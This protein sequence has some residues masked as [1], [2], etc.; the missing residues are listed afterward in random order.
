MGLIAVGEHDCQRFS[1]RIA[2]IKVTFY[3]LRTSYFGLVSGV[4]F[5]LRFV[6]NIRYKLSMDTHSKPIAH[7]IEWLMQH[8]R[9]YCLHF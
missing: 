5:T 3:T 9:H 1:V 2:A 8:A 7:R 6:N 4:S